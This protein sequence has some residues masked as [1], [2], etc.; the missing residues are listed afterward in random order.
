MSARTA[1]I[2]REAM[3]RARQGGWVIGAGLFAALGALTPL[4]I[5][6]DAE[7]LKA[8]G[9][10]LLWI[11]LGLSVFLGVEG[12][13]EDDLRSGV[14]EQLVLSPVSL[15]EAMLIKLAVAWVFL[16]VPLLVAAP[17]LLLAYGGSLLGVLAILLASPGLVFTAG[18]VGALASGQRRGAPLLVFC[19]LPLIIPAL[20]FGPQAGEAGLI[21]FLILGAYS[22][23]AIAICPFLTSAAIRLQLN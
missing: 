18:T 12:L 22:L 1:L 9:P 11:I 21:P 5:G 19:A 14:M 23:Q 20:V 17:M 10:G 8:A 6:N 16:L 13:F 4:A 2:R 3:L 15:A 7:V